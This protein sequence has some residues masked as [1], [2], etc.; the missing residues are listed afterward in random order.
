[1]SRIGNRKIEVP[2]GVTVK[3]ENDIVTVTGQKEACL[4]K[5]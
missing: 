3:V 2:E 1:M 5:C 4:K